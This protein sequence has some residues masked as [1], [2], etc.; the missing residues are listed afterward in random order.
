MEIDLHSERPVKCYWLI[1][2][3][4]LGQVFGIPVD[5]AGANDITNLP[6]KTRDAGTGI[7]IGRSH[8]VI[9]F[10]HITSCISLSTPF[11]C[12]TVWFMIWFLFVSYLTVFLHFFFFCTASTAKQDAEDGPN[13]SCPASRNESWA[14]NWGPGA[15]FRTSLPVL[16]SLTD[17]TAY[18]F[19][20]PKYHWRHINTN[21][22]NR[23]VITKR[24]QK[25]TH[26]RVCIKEVP[27][28]LWFRW[29]DFWH[30]GDQEAIMWEM[31]KCKGEDQLIWTRS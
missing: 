4:I 3:N 19:M 24:Y 13:I 22:K 16:V 30:P 20:N 27:V 14:I 8:S 31:E 21:E 23:S 9:L 28:S 17:L 5:F 29:Y 18:P 26:T 6:G 2:E 11:P 1:D 7:V 25:G 12:L 10:S 15:V